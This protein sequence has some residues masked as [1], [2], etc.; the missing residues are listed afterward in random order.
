M[1]FKDHY[2]LA[3]AEHLVATIRKGI[4]YIENDGTTE[5]ILEVMDELMEQLGYTADEGEG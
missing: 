5:E 2:L 4:P 1:K 3:L